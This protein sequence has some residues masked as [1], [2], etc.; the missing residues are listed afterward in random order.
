MDDLCLLAICRERSFGGA[1]KQVVLC[2]LDVCAH[3][4]RCGCR[5][6]SF[7]RPDDMLVIVH[8]PLKAFVAITVTAQQRRQHQPM[9][10]D[11][12]KLRFASGTDA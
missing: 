9:T 11:E 2:L 7:D 3:K 8:D 4:E 5:V 6:S 12:W 1:L 10:I